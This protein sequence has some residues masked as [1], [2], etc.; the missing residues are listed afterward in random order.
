MALT[1][2]VVQEFL[3]YIESVKG[4][5]AN[6]VTGYKNDLA[7][8]LSYTGESSQIENLGLD[9]LRFCIGC[10]S[11]K[12]AA[13]ASINR[14]IAAVRSLFAYAYKF[15]YIKSNAALELKNVKIPKRIPRFMTEAEVTALC[16]SPDEKALLW[17]AR[18]KAIFEMF[19]SSGCRVSELAGLQI[20]SFRDNYSWA[21]VTGKGKKDRRVFF[22][23][24]ARAALKEYLAQ[25]QA[26]VVE[27][28]IRL[29]EKSLFVNQKGGPLS[30][31]GISWIVSRY[32]GAEGTNHHV[33]PHA[34]RHTF[35]TAMIT[36]G[37]DVR[38]VQDLLGHA[39]ISTT[40]RYTHVTTEKLIEI[41]NKAH[42][43]GKK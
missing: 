25:R 33:S 3:L 20:D 16:N 22:E 10:M 35:A 40:Q 19:Y 6:T 24:Q 9:D 43:H 23:E 42:P 4:F 26:L 2:D 30:V 14:F 21:I 8:F 7:Q 34:F 12:K 38:V 1:K 5:S 18:D 11:E 31:R 15:N 29:Q 39:N 13:A 32:S 27:G 37:A 28:K 41:Y 36:N 17:P